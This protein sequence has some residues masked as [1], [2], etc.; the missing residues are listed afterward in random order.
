M[1]A[2]GD[3]ACPGVGSGRAVADPDEAA[4]AGDDEDVVLG[5]HSTSPED[6]HGMIAAAAVCTEV[7]GRTSHAAVVSRELGGPAVVGCGEGM[8]AA[9]EGR[10]ITVDGT[11]GRSSTA[12]SRSERRTRRR[13]RRWRGSWRGRRS[14]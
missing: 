3:P 10:T 14:T 5:R 8:L 13:Y 4:F 1:L 6:V 12:S 11:A 9:V 7:G 2:R